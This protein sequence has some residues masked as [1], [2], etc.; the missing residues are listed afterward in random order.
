MKIRAAKVTPDANYPMLEAVAA[1][2]GEFFHDHEKLDAFYSTHTD[3]LSGM[4]GVWNYLI[5]AA[6]TFETVSQKYG[7]P[8]E[9]FDWLLAVQDFAAQLYGDGQRLPT[10]GK[11]VEA[12]AAC[13]YANCYYE[14]TRSITGRKVREPKCDGC[15]RAFTKCSCKR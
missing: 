1:I 8:G 13:I 7:V 5:E 2:T 3:T 11:I 14:F 6:K 12:A 9:D 10:R 15:G 4:P